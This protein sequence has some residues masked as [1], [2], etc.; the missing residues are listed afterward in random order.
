MKA[1]NITKG[2][3][4]LFKGEPHQVLDKEFFNLGRGRG[5]LRAKLKNVKTGATIRY[6]FNSVEPVEEIQ[7]QNRRLQYLY[8]TGQEI[9]FMDPQSFEQVNLPMELINDK[10]HFLKEGEVYLVPFYEEL[11]LGIKLPPKVTLK[12]TKAEQG[13]KGNTV[14]G[15]TK[16]V[17]LENGYEVKTPLFVKE[18]DELI[19]NTE[20]GEYVSRAQE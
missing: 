13:V 20:T 10:I 18:G 3:I 19:I 2:M 7:F 11:P 1:S 5:H 9:N 14:T 16:I 17:I 8:Q 6:T 15:A 12:V 4:I